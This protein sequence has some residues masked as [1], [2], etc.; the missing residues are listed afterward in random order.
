MNC[1]TL[2]SDNYLWL[3]CS[4]GVFRLN[5]D[6]LIPDKG[7]IIHPE[8]IISRNSFSVGA[9][10]SLKEDKINKGIAWLGSEANGLT[11][12]VPVTKISIPTI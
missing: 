11:K 4:E 9:I 10:I 8:N 6:K 1:A 2:F 7:N 12:L 5:T 3:G